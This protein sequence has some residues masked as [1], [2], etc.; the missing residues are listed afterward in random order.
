MHCYSKNKT[1]N[2]NLYLLH[3]IKDFFVVIFSFVVIFCCDFF[4]VISNPY[5]V[6]LNNNL[7]LVYTLLNPLS[8]ILLRP[9]IMGE[10]HC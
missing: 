2:K 6:N 4:V 5:R 9:P 3:T 8:K 10:T 1:E 7:G